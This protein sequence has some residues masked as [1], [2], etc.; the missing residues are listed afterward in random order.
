MLG[1]S[2]SARAIHLEPSTAAPGGRRGG[3]GQAI[4]RVASIGYL[5]FLTGPLLI[6]AAAQVTSLAWALTI[7]AVLALFVALAATALRPQ[8]SS[9]ENIKS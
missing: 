9:I 5:G 2:D 3:A 1:Q 4:A 8:P 6:G 7:P